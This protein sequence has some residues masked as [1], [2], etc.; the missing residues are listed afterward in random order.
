VEHEQVPMLRERYASQ[1]PDGQQ[2]C[3]EYYQSCVAR[4]EDLFVQIWFYDSK[5]SIYSSDCHHLKRK[6]RQK[7]GEKSLNV[8]KKISKDPFSGNERS[9]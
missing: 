2:T 5:V 3:G 8:A 1:N 7:V 4:G 6:K 9:F